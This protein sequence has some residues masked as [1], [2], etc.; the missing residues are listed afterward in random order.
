VLHDVD[1]G[2][3]PRPDGRHGREDGDVGVGEDPRHRA[4]PADEVDVVTLEVQPPQ[5]QDDEQPAHCQQGQVGAEA[6]RRPSLRGHHGVTGGAALGGLRE[7]DLDRLH[8]GEDDLTQHDDREQAVALGDVVG[9]ERR[10]SPTLLGD[11][12]HRQLGEDEQ[13]EGRVEDPVAVEGQPADPERLHDGDPDGVGQGGGAVR[14]VTAGDPQPQRHHRQPH[15]G[16]PGHHGHRLTVV[17]QVGHPGREKQRAAHDGEGEQPVDHVVAVVRGGEPGVVHPR[18]PDREEHQDEAEDGV[19]V[20]G[21]QPVVQLGR[22]AG[23]GHD[24]DEVEEQLERRGDAVRL[25]RVPRAHPAQQ[26]HEVHGAHGRSLRPVCW[27]R[28]R[29]SRARRRSRL[30]GRLGPSPNLEVATHIRSEQVLNLGVQRITAAIC[31]AALA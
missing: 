18:P 30:E 7:H 9:V 25:L 4:V 21:G 10:R 17:E 6:T 26:R 20:G 29:R 15:H 11:D 1:R 12:G 23:D 8:A 3:Q 27:P 2:R 14:G 31:D 28:R 24:E 5:G 16:I 22:G 19:V 13:A